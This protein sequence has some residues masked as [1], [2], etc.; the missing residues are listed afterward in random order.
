VRV[1]KGFQAL[2]GLWAAEFERAIAKDFGKVAFRYD[3]VVRFRRARGVF[4]PG[5]RNE[6]RSAAVAFTVSDG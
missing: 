6:L 4:A 5:F 1:G 3:A 2:R